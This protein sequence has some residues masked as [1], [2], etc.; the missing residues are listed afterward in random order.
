MGACAYSDVCVYGC[1]CAQVF[2]VC[3]CVLVSV[4][5]DVCYGVVRVCADI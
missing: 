5:T 4:L 3:E 2:G 1:L